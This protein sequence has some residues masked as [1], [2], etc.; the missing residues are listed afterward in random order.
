MRSILLKRTIIFC[1]GYILFLTVAIA[2]PTNNQD[3]N[4]NGYNKFYYDNGKVSSEGNMKNG[5]PDGYWKTYSPNGKIK[6]E[7]NRKNF[8]LD[9][10]WKFYDENGKIT[11]EINYVAGKK[12]GSKRTYDKD[13][14]VIL[15]EMYVADAKEGETK[16]FYP[17]GKIKTT[18]PFKKGLEN[19]NAFEYSEEGSIITVMEYTNGFMRSQEKINRRDANKWK[20]GKWKE[21]FPGGIT[22]Y[23]LLYYNDTLNGY[24]KEF[25]ADGTLRTITK[26][27]KGKAV[28][29]APELS[30]LDMH[31]DYYAD[32]R[33]KS[34]ESYKDGKP[35]GTFKYYDTLGHITDVKIYKD[36]QLLGEGVY[37]DQG[38]EEGKWKEF[39]PDG[40][41]K[42]EGEYK[43]GAKVGEWKYYHPNGK[44]EQVG[45]YDAKGNP[46]GTWKWYYES[47][48][49]LREETYQKGLREGLMTEYSD[50]GT[51]IAKGEYSEGMKLGPWM[52]TLG[53]YREEGEYKEDLRVGLWKHYYVPSG[54]LRFEGNF[55]EGNPDGKHKYYYPNGKLRAE[56]KYNG[57]KKDGEWIYM[58]Y[59]DDDNML[60]KDGFATQQIPVYLIITYKDGK[61]E[62][63]DGTTVVPLGD[64][65]DI[66]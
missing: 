49:P 12:E 44:T 30:M 1:L 16:Q 7:G 36:G 52:Y 62:K 51:V 3:I 53:D 48:N 43:N 65:S 10:T 23:E 22:H 17:S 15:D 14:K 31:D 24:S 47:G 39:H 38:K 20:Q 63:F 42:G 8:L 11:S 59:A 57:G 33:I 5:K 21:F 45:K 35:E 25:N 28:K 34:R 32:G 56:G 37:N 29:D 18:L 60:D 6:S 46:T 26:Y 64:I 55:I 61:E 2:Q 41:L 50:S 58:F 27:E 19:G 54:Q 40:Q 9:S 66:Q 13:G 4:P